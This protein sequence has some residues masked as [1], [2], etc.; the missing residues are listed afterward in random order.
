[1]NRTLSWMITAILTLCGA[2]MTL[3]SCHDDEIYEKEF[4]DTDTDTSVE[5]TEDELGETT[6]MSHVIFGV[7]DE[8][9]GHALGRRLQGSISSPAAAD[10][11]VIDPSSII[12][13]GINDDDLKTIIRRCESGEASVV[14]TKS[15]FREYYEWAQLYVTGSMLNELDNY[16]G[17]LD[18][19]SPEAAPL[20][21]KVANLIRNAYVTGQQHGS[22]HDNS[23]NGPH[24]ISFNSMNLDWEHVNTWPEEKQNAIMFDAFAQSGSR[25]LFVMNAQATIADGENV[26]NIDMTDNEY[27][28][29]Q[30]ADA[31]T[32]WLNQKGENISQLRA[33]LRRFTHS[34][35]SDGGTV[36]IGDLVKDA[37]TMDFVLDYNY[38]S[39]SDKSILKA[40]AAINIRYT[41][42]SAYDFKN[43]VEYYQ[44]RQNITIMN[45][46]IFTDNYNNSWTTRTG[47]A[48]WD[49]AR[50]AWLSSIETQM[51]LDG[52]GG[53]TNKFVVS[54]G[55]APLNQDGSTSGSTSSGGSTTTTTGHT[56]GISVGLTGGVSGGKP[57]FTVSGGYSHTWSYSE[58]SGT[59]WNTTS[60]WNT[61][62]LTTTLTIN[63]DD[64]A[65]VKWVYDGN[66]P[67]DSDSSNSSNVKNL[68]KNT[69]VT[70]ETVLWQVNN[71][72][73]TYTL[74]AHVDI[75]SSIIKCR[76]DGG[77]ISYDITTG[78]T[79]FSYVTFDLWTPDRYK[80]DWNNVVYDYG[81]L[82]DDQSAA[83]QMK[84]LLNSYLQ[85]NYGNN[86]EYYCWAG[87]FT[88]TEDTIGGSKN[89]C[90]VFQ[91]F[92]NSI[93]GMKQ[94]LRSMGFGG[95]LLFGLKLN[96]KEELIDSIALILDN[97][98]YNVGETFTEEVNGYDLT[99]KVTKKGKEV[100]LDKVP[101]DF[102]GA[103]DIPSTVDG[104]SVTAIGDYCAN[105]NQGITSITIPETVTSIA[106]WAFNDIPNLTEVHVKATL[107]PTLANNN[108][109]NCYDT[110]TLYVPSLLS[111]AVYF[112]TSG[113]RKF[114]TMKVES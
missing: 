112:V 48:A 19:D 92:K 98:G 104:M 63:N 102:T 69:C 60:N 32:R 85:D 30:K 25:Q 36:D 68:L 16:N 106:V 113:W 34:L 28:W 72:K 11:I 82:P 84:T 86:S 93:S 109:F 35:T 12:H 66:T 51:E 9:F 83:A 46:K 13:S 27:E 23:V 59:T 4:I 75:N 71:P 101:D 76:T 65:T 5:K 17:D 78:A 56:D 61:Q 2:T 107:P 54:N 103:L 18:Y 53:K 105:G 97:T 57:T 90:A 1:M 100:E 20:R 22:A 33:G 70:D 77:A 3:T 14:L 24:R 110:A 99:F 8:E 26:S 87:A 67:Y 64:N 38:P 31:V 88:S 74:G 58:S 96:G 49:K 94:T 37:Q 29:G 95:R 15:T 52:E 81:T 43:D 62:D 44:V 39:L 21:K 50:G 6:Q 73:E 47:D 42:Y 108:V 80:Y 111:K 114:K 41:V 10:I 91:T 89:A 79:T 40:D 55:V 45:N 7:W